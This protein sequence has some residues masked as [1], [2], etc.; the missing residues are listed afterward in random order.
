MPLY[1]PDHR[2]SRS[3]SL[4][5]ASPAR[6]LSIMLCLLPTQLLAANQ[7]GAG[8][9][10]VWNMVIAAIVLIFSLASAVLSVA[11]IRQ[12]RGGWRG[13]AVFSLVVLAAW[14][15]L[16]VIGRSVDSNSHRLWPFEIFA[17]AMLNMIYMVSAM[18]IKRIFEK[19]DQEKQ[20][21]N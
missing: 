18:T 7:A 4:F 2:R 16:I 13:A 1:A 15:A 19:A 17:W 10:L 11:A 12:W 9:A 8:S 5:T 6:W 20:A 14:I 3:D 21:N